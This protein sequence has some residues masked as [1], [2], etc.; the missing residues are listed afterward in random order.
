MKLSTSA[1]T[2][3]MAL[4][5]LY[6]CLDRLL[7]NWSILAWLSLKIAYPGKRKPS[8]YSRRAIISGSSPERRKWK[9]RTS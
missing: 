6:S 9:S 7:S 2:S 5:M 4:S 3:A 8:T 1:G